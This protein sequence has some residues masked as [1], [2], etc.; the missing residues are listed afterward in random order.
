MGKVGESPTPGKKEKILEGEWGK[1]E[2]RD[3]RE[4]RK[5]REN[6]GKIKEKGKEKKKKEKM[7]GKGICNL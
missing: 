3:E 2:N 4:N 5:G 7:K 1:D 6:I